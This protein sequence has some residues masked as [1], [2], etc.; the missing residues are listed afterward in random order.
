MWT[1]LAM[2]K[3]SWKWA[4]Y[5]CESPLLTSYEPVTL[6]GSP[7]TDRG[8]KPG[9]AHCAAIV[10]PLS[11]ARLLAL[12]PPGSDEPRYP[13]V[14]NA[15]ETREINA[16]LMA[17][18]DTAV[19]EQPGSGIAESIDVPARGPGKPIADLDGNSAER[20]RKPSRWAQSDPP[21]PPVARWHEPESWWAPSS[22]IGCRVLGC[23]RGAEMPIRLPE[24]V[25]HVRANPF[26]FDSDPDTPVC[27][28]H[29]AQ[30]RGALAGASPGYVID[31][32][33]RNPQDNGR[34]RRIKYPA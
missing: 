28:G 6:I 14:L 15:V 1:N 16:E 26:G 27:S 4:L 13:Y 25:E 20:Y 34:E 8:E 5:L 2:L 31:L 24:V 21:L 11:P 17:F 29:Y 23:G 19:F 10:F 3:A 9:F 18:A 32:R 7:G 22:G 12:F 33:W 30:L